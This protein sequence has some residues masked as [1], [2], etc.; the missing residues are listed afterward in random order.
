MKKIAAVIFVVVCMGIYVGAQTSRHVVVHAGHLLEVK[1]GKVLDDQ[2]LVIEDGKIVSAGAS[3]Q[4]KIP[5][6]R[7]ASTCRTPPCFRD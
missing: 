5:E 7:C 4:A 1:S 2:T 3:A 6:M